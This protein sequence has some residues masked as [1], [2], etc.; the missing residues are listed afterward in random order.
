MAGA[1]S[2]REEECGIHGAALAR[3]RSIGCRCRRMWWP[4][5]P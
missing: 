3:A 2:R 1:A 4:E 5:P